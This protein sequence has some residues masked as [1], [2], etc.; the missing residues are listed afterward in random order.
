MTL[1]SSLIDHG[2]ISRENAFRAFPIS[3]ME[4]FPCWFTFV[5]SVWLRSSV[6]IVF[7]CIQMGNLQHSGN[8]S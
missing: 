6:G 1:E 2:G 7:A 3:Q 8:S 4:Q 5:E